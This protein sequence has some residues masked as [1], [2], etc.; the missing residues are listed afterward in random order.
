MEFFYFS[1]PGILWK[2]QIVLGIISLM[3]LVAKGVNSQLM[4][5]V[6]KGVKSQLMTLVAK[7]MKILM[8]LKGAGSLGEGTRTIGTRTQKLLYHK[9]HG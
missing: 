3:T 5:L 7:G 4:T 6:A 1:S 8:Q 2:S 9:N